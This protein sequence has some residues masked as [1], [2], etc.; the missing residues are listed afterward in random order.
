MLD[1][2][3]VTHEQVPMKQLLC[4]LTGAAFLCVST[5]CA[6]SSKDLSSSYVSPIQYQA[7]DCGQ[8]AA[9][10]QRIQAR[11]SELGGRT[12][13]FV[14]GPRAPREHAPDSL[15]QIIGQ[16]EAE[17]LARHFAGDADVH[18]PLCKVALRELR[19]REIR[20]EF[21]RLTIGQQRSARQ[22]VAELAGHYGIASR[23][24]WRLLKQT[25]KTAPGRPLN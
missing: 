17:L 16:H 23:H 20:A 2:T 1:C 12:W 18:I 5:G 15:A 24:V 3:H 11:V 10:S 9:E 4:I 14:K 13:S 6:T 22:A 8:L 19:D 7:Y 25:D 21:D